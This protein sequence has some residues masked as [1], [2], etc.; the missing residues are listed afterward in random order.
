MMARRVLELPLPSW[1]SSSARLER[2]LSRAATNDNGMSEPTA[3]FE[4]VDVAVL[5]RIVIPFMMVSRE[6]IGG[7]RGLS[8]EFCEVPFP[9]GA[10]VVQAEKTEGAWI[11]WYVER[12]EAI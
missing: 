12:V 9:P 5:S 2:G 7:I 1:Q 8:R 4:G 6:E 11:V 3:K 10:R